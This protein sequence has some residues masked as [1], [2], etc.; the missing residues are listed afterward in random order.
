MPAALGPPIA[1]AH[2]TSRTGALGS[3]LSHSQAEGQD[4]VVATL[5]KGESCGEA[6]LLG[7]AVAHADIMVHSPG[8]VMLSLCHAD[9]LRALKEILGLRQQDKLMYL[10]MHPLFVGR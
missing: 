3:N 6:V 9:F 5:R 4:R 8:A 2:P 10:R 1:E 7:N